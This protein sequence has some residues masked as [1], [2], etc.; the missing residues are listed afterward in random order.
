MLLR[1]LKVVSPE[2]WGNV[3]N[4]GAVGRRHKITGQHMQYVRIGDGI[5]RHIGQDLGVGTSNEVLS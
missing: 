5:K 4:T 1:Q 2:R 3:H